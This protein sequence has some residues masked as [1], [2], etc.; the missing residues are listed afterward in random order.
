VAV[1]HA[2]LILA[3]MQAA[4]VV[5]E[6]ADNTTM[7][8]EQEMAKLTLVAVVVATLVELVATKLEEMVEQA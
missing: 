2:L 5:E 7:A 3:Q 8:T 6:Q 4:L 1:V